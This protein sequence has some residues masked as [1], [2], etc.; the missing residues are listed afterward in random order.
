MISFCEVNT[1]ALLPLPRLSVYLSVCQASYERVSM[2]F[3][4]NIDIGP[5]NDEELSFSVMFWT[6]ERI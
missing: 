1:L 3:T 5:M 2:K 4:G 6:A